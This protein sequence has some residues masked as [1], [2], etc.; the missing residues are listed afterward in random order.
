MGFTFNGQHSNDF[1]LYFKTN[2]LPYIAE[3]RSESV[4]VQGVDGQHVFED[5][6]N[7]TQIE[8]SCV[9]IG[10]TVLSRRRQARDIAEW[11][12]DTGTLIFDYEKSIE[13]Q[14]V[15]T[16]NNIYAAMNGSADEFT[17][18]FECEPYQL[19]T[20]YN[21]G[22]TWGEA[23]LAW[24]YADIPWGGYERTFEVTAGETIAVVNAGT[25]KA[26][27]VISLTGTAASVTIGDFTFTN[28]SGTVYIDCKN[29]V[30]YSLS[31]DTKV[32]EIADFSGEFPE[33]D[34]GTNEFD[35]SGTITSLT[36][37]FDYKNTYL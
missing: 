23:E 8:I 13:Y 2:A 25:Y 20:F 18:I 6:Y 31:G 12:A 16:T 26:L 28:L 7:N 11:L 5:G 3:K 33:L 19:Q 30:V 29:K 4:E 9:V 27:P 10:A 15:K 36:I 1:G 17:I 35:I 22:L 24:G 37:E 21:D 14:V 34:P 32:N